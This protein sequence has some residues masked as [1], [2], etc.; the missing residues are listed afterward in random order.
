MKGMQKIRRGSGFKGV[1]SYLLDHDAPE[2]I[3]GTI[4]KGSVNQM[5]QE[6]AALSQTRSDIQKPVWHNSLRLPA[7]DHLS[8]KQWNAIATDYMKKLGFDESAQWIAIRHNHQDGEHLHIVANRVL[9]RRC[10]IRR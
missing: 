2:F 1:L 10:V 3:A 4:S 9:P 5:T 6:F 8:E 7:G